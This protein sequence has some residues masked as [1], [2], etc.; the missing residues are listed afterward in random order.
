MEDLIDATSTSDS[1]LV[2]NYKYTKNKR[3]SL[4]VGSKNCR[5]YVGGRKK[6]KVNYCDDHFEKKSIKQ[7]QR[8]Y[9]A[10][11]I[12]LRNKLSIPKELAG[13]KAHYDFD[14]MINKK[15]EF[16]HDLEYL[17]SLK[18]DEFLG[19]TLLIK[20]W[21]DG[22][23]FKGR[24]T[25]MTNSGQFALSRTIFRG[26]KA[27]RPEF[28][29]D[30]DTCWFHMNSIKE[31]YLIEEN[32]RTN[33]KNVMMDIMKLKIIKY[34]MFLCEF[35]CRDMEEDVHETS[36]IKYL[37]KPY[38][39]AMDERI[40]KIGDRSI[41]HCPFVQKM[42]KKF[43][44]GTKQ[45]DFSYVTKTCW[46]KKNQTYFHPKQ[47]WWIICSYKDMVSKHIRRHQKED[48]EPQDDQKDEEPTQPTANEKVSSK[49][50]FIGW[51]R[52]NMITEIKSIKEEN[53]T[54]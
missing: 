25:C 17:S 16:K 34:F 14:Y 4:Y 15:F 24:L 10:G 8:K 37:T 49:K 23:P 7:N 18:Q 20:Y 51:D 44:Y 53:R 26:T 21:L 41:I 2:L 12:R 36:P 32:K 48:I 13:A 42:T 54:V 19:K 30:D 9:D 29:S 50:S 1:E 5:K 39:D 11:D 45:T 35:Q 22:A 3:L 40:L 47:M 31:M 46:S 27:S 38:V 33:I 6:R 52:R 43:V 28:N